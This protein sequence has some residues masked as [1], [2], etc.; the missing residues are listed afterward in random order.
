MVKRALEKR[1]CGIVNVYEVQFG[2]MPERGATG[3][4]RRNIVQNT[5][6]VHVVHCGAG[7]RF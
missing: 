2:F 4:C 3:A 5:E 1:C 7:E 6:V